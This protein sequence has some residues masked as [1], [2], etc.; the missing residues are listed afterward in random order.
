MLFFLRSLPT[1]LLQMD[2]HARCFP[3]MYRWR[4]P[5]AELESVAAFADTQVGRGDIYRCGSFFHSHRHHR[6]D[7]LQQ[8]LSF[9]SLIS[10][11]FQLSPFS[12]LDFFPQVIE[13]TSQY[14]DRS[15]KLPGDQTTTIE[16]DIEV[17]VF[18]FGLCLDHVLH[19]CPWPYPENDGATCLHVL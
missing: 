17:L 5:A 3:P 14:E 11:S 12:F 9:R 2:R 13:L 4:L 7:Q 16:M 10:S 19:V 18:L 1:K 6:S 15:G 8:C